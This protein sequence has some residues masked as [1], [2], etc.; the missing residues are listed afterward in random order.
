MKRIAFALTVALLSCTSLFAQKTTLTYSFEDVT[1][2]KDPFVQLLGVNNTGLIAGYHGASVNKGFTLTLPDTFTAEN[3]PKS[4]QTQVIGI[5]SLTNPG[6]A[7]FYIDQAGVTH[8]FEHCNGVWLTVDFPGTTFNQ[9]LGINNNAE[10]A[11][12]YQ[13]AAGN[14]HPYLYDKVGG[15][16]FEELYLPGTTSAQATGINNSQA[17]VGF[18]LDSNSVSHGWEL[19]NGSYIK[20]NFPGSTSTQALGINNNDE[21]VGSYTDSSNAMHGFHY[22]KGVWTSIDDPN[23]VG[24]TLVNGINDNGTIVGFYTISSTVNTG[25]VGTPE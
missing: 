17:V 24:I 14:F 21:I 5:N 4:A 22:A 16:V 10:G 12:Y 15:G 6:T 25:F 20:L 19:I 3:F 18:Y 1:Y 23:G 9:I 7:G 13:D 2:P 11:G 8:G